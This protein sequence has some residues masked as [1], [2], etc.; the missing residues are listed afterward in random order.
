MS[1]TTIKRSI[2][3]GVMVL[4]ETCMAA[5]VRLPHTH[6]E[7][8]Y[9]EARTGLPGVVDAIDGTLIEIKRLE[10]WEGWYCRKGFPAFNMQAVGDDHQLFMSFSIRSGRT[11]TSL[12]LIYPSLVN[13]VIG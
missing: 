9:F 7:W 5:T 1:S 6:S 8:K 10:Q 4:V 2:W 11:M 3:E 12:S 13:T